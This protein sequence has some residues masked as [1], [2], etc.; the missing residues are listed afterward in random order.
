MR[1][2]SRIKLVLRLDNEILQLRRLQPGK[3]LFWIFPEFRVLSP[4]LLSC[5][6]H[7][8]SPTTLPHLKNK[9]SW[10]NKNLEKQKIYELIYTNILF[11]SFLL[12]ASDHGDYHN[13]SGQSQTATCTCKI[14]AIIELHSFNLGWVI[15]AKAPI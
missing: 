4:E 5:W 2:L 7:T 14:H 1:T 6:W 12:D 10:S 8:C 9:F 11:Y 13:R 15:W 3:L